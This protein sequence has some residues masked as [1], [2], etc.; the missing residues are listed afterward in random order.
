VEVSL[1]GEPR[2]REQK[3]VTIL[4]RLQSAVLTPTV[5]VHPQFLRVSTPDRILFSIGSYPRQRPIAGLGDAASPFSE[6]PTDLSETAAFSTELHHVGRI[7][8]ISGPSVE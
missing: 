7:G 4:N 5:S 6:S 3:R 2:S 8:C 1:G